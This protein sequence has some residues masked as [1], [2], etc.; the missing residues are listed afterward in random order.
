MRGGTH[1]IVDGIQDRHQLRPFRQ[2]L[3]Q[4]RIQLRKGEER[5]WRKAQGMGRG[6]AGQGVG[7]P[8]GAG[9]KAP[10]YRPKS[11]ALW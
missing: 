8:D 9:Q 10:G 3:H 7:T 4:Q 1:G 6:W 2:R 11:L 5:K